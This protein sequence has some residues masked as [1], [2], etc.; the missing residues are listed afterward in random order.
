MQ[1]GNQYSI[2]SIDTE[3]RR[4]RMRA[5]QNDPAKMQER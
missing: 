5:N 4:R 3:E 1:S 2:T